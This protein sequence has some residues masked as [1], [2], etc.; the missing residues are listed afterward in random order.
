MAFLCCLLVAGAVTGG[1]GKKAQVRQPRV[2]VTVARVE[3]RTVPLELAATGT[4]EAVQSASVGSQVGGV[5]TA[6]LIRE[7][8]DV[9]AGQPLI[10]LDPRPLHAA[11]DQT[12]GQL[13][14]D[15][16]QYLSARADADR[17]AKLLEMQVLSQADY[18][19]KRAAADALHA[20]VIADSATTRRAQLDL[21]Y[22]TI[23]SPVSGRAGAFNVHVGDYVK[24]ASSDPLVTVVQL[25]PIRVRFTIP[26]TQ[27]AALR[28]HATRD[29]RVVARP[30]SGDSATVEGRLTFIDNAVDPSTGTLLLK[31]E[32]DNRD[33]R[34]VPG[35]MVDTR[36]VLANESDR[37]VVPAVAVTTGQQGTY[38]YVMNADS[39]ASPRNVDVA[40]MQGDLAVVANG[41][42]PG[43][44]VVTDGQ[45][46]LSPGSRVLVRKPGGAGGGASKGAAPGGGSSTPARGARPT[47]RG[48]ST[49][50]GRGAGSPS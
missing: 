42:E 45:F 48:G 35:Q 21:A 33:G 18:D 13:G 7:G 12:K 1:C 20:S 41:L 43:E 30:A 46:R 49:G 6:L 26:E 10:Q 27:V 34:L 36:L 4:V 40:R 39:T 11:Y 8:Q 19:T 25:H 16:A 32:F 31:G 50:G 17:A 24:A 15:R 22:A 2:P 23:R 44:T 14:R 5:V 47:D 28:G 37:L 3:R 9:R 38:V 29:I